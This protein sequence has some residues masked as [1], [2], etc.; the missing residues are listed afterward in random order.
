M[1]M[2]TEK[3]RSFI[4]PVVIQEIDGNHILRCERTD[5]DVI[6]RAAHLA[7]TVRVF[8]VPLM[9]RVSRSISSTRRTVIRRFRLR[10]LC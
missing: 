2:D 10:R 6:A 8:Q 1:I 3:I 7:D 5:P 9:S 4:Q